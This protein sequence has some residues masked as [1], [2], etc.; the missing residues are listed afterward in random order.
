MYLFH[1]LGLHNS[2]P[3]SIPLHL[4]SSLIPPPVIISFSLSLSLYPSSFNYPQEEQ[5]KEKKNR[6]F[7]LPIIRIHHLSSYPI[8]NTFLLTK[9][10]NKTT[11]DF[12]L[13]FFFFS[14][15]ASQQSQARCP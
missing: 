1:Q 4:S 5:Q 7:R 13:D 6:H 11:N 12:P 10:K 9:K 14:P 15:K 3:R 2:I 8:H